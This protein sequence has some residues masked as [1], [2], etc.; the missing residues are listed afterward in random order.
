MKNTRYNV[1]RRVIAGALVLA[2]VLMM[3]SPV[4]AHV[5]VHPASGFTVG[6]LHPLSGLDHLLAMV[7]VGMLGARLGGRAVWLVP[8]SFI[9]MMGVGAALSWADVAMQGVE[10]GIAASLLVLGG[11]LVLR[12][13]L[14][15]ALAMAIVGS[16]AIFHGYAHG[17]E[18]PATTAGL[19][20]GSGFVAATAMLHIL[21]IT[22]GIGL[23]RLMEGRA[24]DLTRLCGGFV[25]LTGIALVSGVL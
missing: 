20:Y 18:M 19:S 22:L 11:L 10:L 8:V 24:A 23:M 7:A 16:F 14:P 17:T 2:S 15:T 25:A 4:S 21:G 6:F 1:D 5:G 13:R 9:L 12:T 3:S